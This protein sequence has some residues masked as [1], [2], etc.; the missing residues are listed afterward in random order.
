MKT[1]LLTALTGL[2]GL[3]LALWIVFHEGVRDIY[4]VLQIAGWSLLWVIPAHIASVAVDARGWET[5]LRPLDPARHARLPF[6]VWVATV[7]EAIDRLLPVANIGG[8]LVGIRLLAV[9]RPISGAV[10][11]ASVLVEVLLTIVSQYLFTAIGV[12]LLVTLLHDT[13]TTQ[14]FAIGL[15]VT[16]PMPIFLY[17]LLRNGRLFERVRRAAT[18]LLGADNRLLTLLTH[19][20]TDLDDHLRHLL[21]MPRPLGSAVVW[22]LAGMVLGGVETWF[23]LWLLGHPVSMW[24]ALALE[25]LALA[26]RNFAFF[27]PAGIGVQ[28]ASLV[29]FGSLIGLPADVCVALSLTKRLRDVGFG[30]PALASWQWVEGRGLRTRL[31]TPH[32]CEASS[33]TGLRHNHAADDPTDHSSIAQAPM[34]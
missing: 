11:T 33:P 23:A 5:L 19:S 12:V 16:L 30:I 1:K 31:A 6:L 7:R 17:F 25:S 34:K 24:E 10:S 8:E 32:H 22:Q 29:V 27:V 28:E 21:R 13:E 9:H 18:R 4:G 3:G 15:L 2:A 20:A 26:V 14:G